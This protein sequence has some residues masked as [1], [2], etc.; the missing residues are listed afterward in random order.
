MKMKR[1]LIAAAFLV[2][3]LAFAFPC[4]ASDAYSAALEE[5]GA[6][7]LRG[8]LAEETL[9]YLDKIGYGDIDFY[10]IIDT[11]PTAIID[12]VISVLSGKLP[13][14]LKICARLLAVIIITAAA[15]GFCPPD[16]RSRLIFS[17]ISGCVLIL[18][19]FAPA[20]SVISAG[21]SAIG[22]CAG[23]EKALIPVMAG[24]LTA[25]GNPALAL[26][27]QSFVFAAAQ[28]ITALV[29]EGVVPIIGMCGITGMLASISPVLKLSAVSDFLRKSVITVLTAAAAMFSGILALKGVLASSADS[30]A[31]KGIKL[32]VSSF[33]PVL[34]S[35][36]SEAYSSVVGSLALIKNAL[37]AFAV[38]AVALTLLPIII[39]LLLWVLSLRAAG[40]C[41]EL[42][43]LEASAGIC[44]SAGTT[45]S[46]TAVLL[47]YCAAVFF[48]SSGLV[49]AL[50][51]GA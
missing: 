49:I 51:G 12:I 32:A 24:V 31:S 27:Y 4:G 43:G 14:I 19:V 3:L 7:S 10:S 44:R 42:L 6:D 50:K 26:S 22:V 20:Y 40:M 34:G 39:E 16:D 48:V 8:M 38:A 2:L 35:A 36:L 1:I 45:L 9:G 21:V 18:T 15:E 37:G 25:C 11:K 13:G 23:F 41:A 46:L 28:G 47:V 33:V 30:L 5:S 29:N 17:L